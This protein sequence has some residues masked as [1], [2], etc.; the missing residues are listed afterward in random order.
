[1][2]RNITVKAVL[3][4]DYRWV[5]NDITAK[6]CLFVTDK[7][8]MCRRLVAFQLQLILHEDSILILGNMRLGRA[9]PYGSDAMVLPR[10]FTLTI[11]GYDI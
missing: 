6:P 5:C 1:V 2:T 8:V 4:I 11:F 9:V 10:I 7:I 3:R